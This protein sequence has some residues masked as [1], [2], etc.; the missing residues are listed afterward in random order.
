MRTF[1]PNHEMWARMNDA[2][3]NGAKSVNA[4]ELLVTVLSAATSILIH[5]G[6]AKDDAQARAHLAA[7]LLSPETSPNV[8]SLLPLLQG[9]LARLGEMATFDDGGWLSS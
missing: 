4:A 1:K 5:S 6:A 3:L 8:G 9:E 2:A 7:M